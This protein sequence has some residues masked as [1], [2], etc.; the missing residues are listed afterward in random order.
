MT[1]DSTAAQK[2]KGSIAPNSQ[3]LVFQTF[4]FFF[5]HLADIIYS[6]YF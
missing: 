4:F 3:H 2:G 6:I 1:K 5:Y